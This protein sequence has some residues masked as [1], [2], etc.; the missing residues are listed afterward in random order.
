MFL[1]VVVKRVV[2]VLA[3]AALV[4][5]GAGCLGDQQGGAGAGVPVWKVDPNTLIFNGEVDSSA[6]VPQK[7]TLG[8]EGAE[9]GY[10]IE[11]GESWLEAFPDSGTLAHAGSVEVTVK[12]KGCNA[13]GETSAWLR[14]TGGGSNAR[15]KVTRRCSA[16]NGN[17]SASL[18]ASPREGNAPLTVNFSVSSSDPD[19]DP[20]S[21]TLNFGDGASEDICSGGT[22]HEYASAGSYTAT[23]SVNDGH[24]G[25][26]SASE[27]ITVAGGSGGGEAVVVFAAGDIAYSTDNDEKTHDL[28]KDLAPKEGEWYVLAL[29]DLAY[30]DGKYDEFMEYYDPNTSWGDFK[31]RTYPITG[32]HEYHTSGASGYFKYWGARGHKDTNGWYKVKIGDWSIYALNSNLSIGGSSKQYQWLEE[33]L[34]GDEARCSLMMGHHPRYSNGHHGNS[35]SMD[36][37]WDLFYKSGGELYLSGHDHAYERFYP[38]DDGSARDEAHGV[39]QFVVGTG[40]LPLYGDVGSGNHLAKKVTGKYGVLE[41]KLYGDHYSWRFVDV[42]GNVLDQGSGNCHS[43]P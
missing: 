41:L 33:Q 42:G 9:A 43:A 4:M 17:P 34:E 26:A 11:P 14:V 10:R 36:A 39:T 38:Q 19:G 31:S 12:V 15:L 21:C 18:T 28:I 23:L 8:N 27:S 20:L 25:R 37:A 1:A 22:S 5:A 7:F 3:V 40:G 16:G 24:G 6:P 29:G 35:S 32:N 30:K 2:A 13:A